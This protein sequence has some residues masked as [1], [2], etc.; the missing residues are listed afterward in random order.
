MIKSIV[1]TSQLY[2][3]GKQTWRDIKPYQIRESK[4]IWSAY[5]IDLSGKGSWKPQ[6]YEREKVWKFDWSCLS[7]WSDFCASRRVSPKI[8]RQF[9]DSK[10]LFEP[11]L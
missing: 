3:D 5:M 4:F 7:E 2:D 8:R 11:L 1:I 6:N 9:A 10:S